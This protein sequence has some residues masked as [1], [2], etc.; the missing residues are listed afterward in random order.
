MLTP[1]LLIKHEVH[2]LHHYKR[3]TGSLLYT[4]GGSAYDGS[5][6]IEP[7]PVPR[8]VRLRLVITGYSRNT[9][10]LRARGKCATAMPRV[11]RGNGVIP[12][13]GRQTHTRNVE[14]QTQ[15]VA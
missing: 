10:E 3:Q 12:H 9:N 15:I 1:G 13:T 5:A 4:Q 8:V 7:Y 2:R 14:I 11:I 6:I